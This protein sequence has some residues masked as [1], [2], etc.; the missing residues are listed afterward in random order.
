MKKILLFVSALSLATACIDQDF[1]LDKIEDLDFAL[2][3]ENSEF[4]LPLANI[5]VLSEALEGAN[6]VASLSD[7]FAEADIWLPS[8]CNVLDLAL[9]RDENSRG[10]NSYI[11]SL[12]DE[13][14][15]ELKTN[16]QKREKVATLIADQYSGSMTVPPVLAQQGVSLHDYI[17]LYLTDP[18]Y[19]ADIKQSISDLASA[20]LDALYAVEPVDTQLDGLDIDEGV[21]DA[22]TGEGRAL[23][24]YGSVANYIPF[25]CTGIL[26]IKS[27]ASSDEY[28]DEYYNDYYYFDPVE[29]EINLDYHKTETELRHVE[30]TRDVLNGLNSGATLSVSFMPT[31]YSPGQILPA[32]DDSALEIALKLY[33]KGGLNISDL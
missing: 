29:V 6:T 14:F 26:V 2:G 1:D 16:S 22:L 4:R 28:D 25:D 20:H 12:V 31:T 3:N 18:D 13:L 21:I 9:L 30:I 33:K 15:G 11:N 5:T 27:S 32:N 8:S 19:S 24:L 17:A 23:Q 10:V 7:M